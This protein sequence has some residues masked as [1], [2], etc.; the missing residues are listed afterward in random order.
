[1][2]SSVPVPGFGTELNFISFSIVRRAGVPTI[3]RFLGQVH[4]RLGKSSESIF[5][6]FR[7]SSETGFFLRN[8]MYTVSLTTPKLFSTPIFYKI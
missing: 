5:D 1:M 8:V 2:Q 4:S 3:L 6:P 7:R